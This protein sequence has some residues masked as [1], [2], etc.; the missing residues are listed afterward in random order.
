MLRLGARTWMNLFRLCSR[1]GGRGGGGVYYDPTPGGNGP[2]EDG[3]RR[4][5]R[6]EGFASRVSGTVRPQ[7]PGVGATPVAAP[8]RMMTNDVSDTAGLSGGGGGGSVGPLQNF[9]G[10]GRGDQ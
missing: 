8:R 10:V 5:I 7:D 4:L 3:K 2:T 6:S 9:G 1:D